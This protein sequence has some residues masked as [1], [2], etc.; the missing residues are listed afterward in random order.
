VAVVPDEILLFYCCWVDIFIEDGHM[1]CR[2]FGRC[3]VKL[4]PPRPTWS[5]SFGCFIRMLLLPGTLHY[6]RSSDSHIRWIS[7][8]SSKSLVNSVAFQNSTWSE[9]KKKK[10]I[11]PKIS[12]KILIQRWEVWIDNYP[13]GRSKKWS[14]SCCCI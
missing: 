14:A 13:V 12:R 10:K 11:P 3:C 4:K 8:N 6:L 2:H 5:K 9:S 7:E 1:V